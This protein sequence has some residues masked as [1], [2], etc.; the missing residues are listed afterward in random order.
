MK[1]LVLFALV[2]FTSAL[3]A[4]TVDCSKLIEI[5]KTYYLN[6][7]KT[8]FTGKC[9]QWLDKTHKSFESE[10]KNGKLHGKEI[11]W[12]RNGIIVSE[13]NYKE[14]KYNG[15]V[16]HYKEDGIIKSKE[17]YVED[18]KNGIS[19]YYHPN[20]KKESE[21][22]F[23]NCNEDGKWYFWDEKGTLIKEVIYKDAI[24]VSEKIFNK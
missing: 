8:P 20:G 7:S 19:T 3:I 16:N 12:N 15:F 23:I 22:N 13:S 5:E 11:T 18:Y 6:D 9:V 21:G 4:Q 17:K 10:Y 24:I 2:L 1:N 14:G